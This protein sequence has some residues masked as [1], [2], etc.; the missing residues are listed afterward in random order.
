MDGGRRLLRT[1]G[2]LGASLTPAPY[3]LAAANDPFAFP[4]VA[5]S[6]PSLPHRLW[7]QRKLNSVVTRLAGGRF[8]GTCLV[9]ALLSGTIAYGLVRGGAY[10]AFVASEGTIPNLAARAA[11]FGIKAVTITG[12]REL[13]EGEILALAGISP[14]DSLVFLN[15]ADTRARLKAVPL[16]KEASVSKLYPNRLLIEVEERQPFAIWQKD[17]A[18]S[19]VAADGTPID[20][21]KDPRFERLPFVVGE[22]ANAHLAEF[23]TILDAAGEMRGRV[24]AGI[25]VAARRWTLRLDNGVSVDLP[26]KDPAEAVTHLAKVEH[27]GHVLEKDVISIDMRIPGRLIARLTPDAAAAWAEALAKKSKKKSAAT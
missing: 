24:R 11:G 16:I 8:T 6:A 14:R 3:A 17:G 7:R 21:M 12:T 18:V 26:E 22:G 27:D 9:L 1:L 13:T 4:N 25:Y 10:A 15:V 20:D 5:R 19:I 23:V 2:A